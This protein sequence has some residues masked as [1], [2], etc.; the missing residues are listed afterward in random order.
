MRHT[1][2]DGY[3][4]P[5]SSI[6]RQTDAEV[7]TGLVSGRVQL[8]CRI[9]MLSHPFS[10]CICHRRFI[11]LRLLRSSPPTPAGFGQRPS[12][13]LRL[14]PTSVCTNI[15]GLCSLGN[16]ER[17][18][19]AKAAPLRVK[20]RTIASPIPLVPPVTRTRLS[21]NSPSETWIGINGRHDR[22]SSEAILSPESL[23]RWSSS[24]GLPGNSPVSRARTVTKSPSV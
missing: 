11:G 1:H 17:A 23:K 7:S 20:R 16:G 21:L 13:R 24:T 19:V 10:N 12:E 4:L 6:G 5:Q 9:A 2:I 3:T 14:S 8:N 18:V 15:D 22:I